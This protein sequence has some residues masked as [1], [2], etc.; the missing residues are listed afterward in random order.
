MNTITVLNNCGDATCINSAA[1]LDC[2]GVRTLIYS[3]RNHTYNLYGVLN[4]NA[5]I[6]YRKRFLAIGSGIN[7]AYGKIVEF[8]YLALSIFILNGNLNLRGVESFAYVQLILN[9]ARYHSYG[10][11]RSYGNLNAI[12]KLCISGVG[13]RKG[14]FAGSRGVDS[15]ECVLFNL[16]C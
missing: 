10:R 5:L 9:A 1:K 4:G 16:K 12:S 13:Y 11:N 6:G 15:G 3:Q 8:N 14:L 2:F 7:S